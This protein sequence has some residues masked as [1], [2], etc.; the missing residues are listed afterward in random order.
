MIYLYIGSQQNT[1][2]YK[3]DTR[4][5][6]KIQTNCKQAIWLYFR[7]V[8]RFFCFCIFIYFAKSPNCDDVPT[9]SQIMDQDSCLGE[10]SGHLIWQT[11]SGAYAGGHRTIQQHK[12]V[13]RLHKNCC[14]PLN[15]DP[16]PVISA[17]CRCLFILD[18]PRAGSNNWQFV[19]RLRRQGC[20]NCSC[21]LR[22]CHMDHSGC[23]STSRGIFQK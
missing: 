12:N 21:A 14:T 9:P 6:T 15:S 13:H 4:K 22:A 23:T 5:H 19:P 7:F 3:I 2:K 17:I 10:L 18:G 1:K 11:R 16:G 20:C 8:F